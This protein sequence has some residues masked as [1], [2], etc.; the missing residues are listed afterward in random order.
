MVQQFETAQFMP[1]AVRA[2]LGHELV[3]YATSS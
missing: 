1:V 3:C 2:D